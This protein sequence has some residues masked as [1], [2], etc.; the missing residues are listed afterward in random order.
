MSLRFFNLKIF[1][2]LLLILLC[3]YST[4]INT[5]I[6]IN[7]INIVHQRNDSKKGKKIIENILRMI[8]LFNTI[9]VFES[10]NLKKNSS[11]TKI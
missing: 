4:L 3:Y 7:N 2:S 5:K 8:N 6:Y 9:S 10:V 1:W 11:L